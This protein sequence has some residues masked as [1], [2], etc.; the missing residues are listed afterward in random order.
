MD[1]ALRPDTVRRV[2]DQEWQ[3][4]LVMVR[5]LGQKVAELSRRMVAV[6]QRLDSGA[7]PVSARPQPSDG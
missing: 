2:S 4:F 7:R 1:R 3:A 6:E 5:E